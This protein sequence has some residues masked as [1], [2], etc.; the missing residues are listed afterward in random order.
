MNMP[1]G[2]GMPAGGEGETMI[3]LVIV[4]GEMMMTIHTSASAANAFTLFAQAADDLNIMYKAG[5]AHPVQQM[6]TFRRTMNM[7]TMIQ[8]PVQV[9]T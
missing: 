2:E 3:F 8:L 7:N 1:P 9:S 5:I 4:L 6:P